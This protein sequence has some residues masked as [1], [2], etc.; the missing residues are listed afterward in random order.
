M[1][2][3]AGKPMSCSQGGHAHKCACPPCG[4]S[5]VAICVIGGAAE[6]APQIAG[7]V[8]SPAE[9]DNWNPHTYFEPWAGVH[10]PDSARS[11]RRSPAARLLRE[12]AGGRVLEADPARRGPPQAVVDRAV[13]RTCRRERALEAAAVVVGILGAVKVRVLRAQ[14]GGVGVPTLARDKAWW[15]ACGDHD[16][17]QRSPLQ[18]PAILALPSF[19]LRPVYRPPTACLISRMTM[20]GYSHV[21]G[22]AD[23]E[24]HA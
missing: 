3:H 8:F 9:D 15:R 20:V 2:Q 17:M 10:E 6:G 7:R 19:P 16:K 12:P 23:S 5:A 11:G 14:R 4:L 22:H 18:T 13:D 1:T 21:Q 24:S